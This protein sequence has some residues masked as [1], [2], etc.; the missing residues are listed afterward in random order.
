MTQGDWVAPPA[1]EAV[2]S[3]VF[4]GVESSALMDAGVA[5]G[6]SVKG[7]RVKGTSAGCAA[8]EDAAEKRVKHTAASHASE[9]Q[10]FAALKRRN[11]ARP[12]QRGEAS[13]KRHAYQF[14]GHSQPCLR[15]RGDGVN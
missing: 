1:A 8:K 15:Q 11:N 13:A 12:G 4:A 7:N 14:N 3:G 5:N 10:K 6:S 2:G 9:G